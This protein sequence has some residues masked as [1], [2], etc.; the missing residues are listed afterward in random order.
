MGSKT[1]PSARKRH[2]KVPPPPDPSGTRVFT[3][4]TD[5]IWRKPR[6]RLQEESDAH[7]RRQC[8]PRTCREGFHPDTKFVSEPERRQQLPTT[9]T[10]NPSPVITPP[11]RPQQPGNTRAAASTNATAPTS[12]G[13]R[14]DIQRGPTLAGRRRRHAAHAR[15]A[16]PATTSSTT[17]WPPAHVILAV[18]HTALL[19]STHATGRGTATR[20]Q[21]PP[22]LTR[23]ESSW[24]FDLPLEAGAPPGG[25]HHTLGGGASLRDPLHESLTASSFFLRSMW[26]SSYQVKW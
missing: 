2:L 4:A 12:Q 5:W 1:A 13:R 25:M 17:P 3:R 16:T 15:P 24:F 11:S 6:R 10:A 22:K 19:H 18:G 9:P 26:I 20:D 23:F 14:P 7:G 8:R 21:K